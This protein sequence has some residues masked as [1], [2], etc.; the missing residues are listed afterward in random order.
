MMKQ[1]TEK[2][3]AN[4]FIES[5]DRKI[6][7]ACLQGEM[8][9]WEALIVRYQRLIYSIPLKARLSQDDAADIFQA[10]CL[11][12]YE[13]LE[14]LRDHEKLS[15]W[16]ITTTTRESWRLL[17]R[18]K[19]EVSVDEPDSED[20]GQPFNLLA[21]DAPLADE[22][23]MMLEQQ[24]TIRQAVAALPER[25]KN[26]V[27]M[28]FYKKDDLSYTDIAR[29]LDMPVASIGPTRARCLEKLKKLLHGKI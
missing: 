2:T 21:S 1:K 28:L 16:I 27:T 29:Q 22:Q 18:Q 10:V 19:R 23:R 20:D 7:E 8:S 25:C 13:K 12:L 17:A 26:L 24:Q 15:A 11:K 4:K 14:T 9:A 5:D 6:I 3:P